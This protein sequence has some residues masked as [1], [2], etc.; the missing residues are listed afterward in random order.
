[1]N[2]LLLE[3]HELAGEIAVVTDRRAAHVR[4]ILGKRA[5]ESVRVGL[6]GGKLGQGTLVRVDDGEVEI[7]CVF[8]TE[9]PPR[10]PVT[11]VLALPRPPVLRRVLQH[12]ASAGVGR[13]VLVNAARVE[14]SYWK[15]PALEPATMRTQLVLGLEQG[16][17][18]IVP[19]VLLRPRFRPFVEDELPAL[20]AG[21]LALVA[22]PGAPPCPVDVAR[23]VTLVVGPEGG[24]VPFELDA[25]A[26]IGFSRVGL[27]RRILRVETA[28]VALLARVGL[29]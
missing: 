25:L 13:I 11:L 2:V 20:A 23:A 9:P 8:D 1:V 22:D 5:G 28:V 27:G 17:D 4:E 19:D 12:V 24:L 18:T 16:G 21:S 26:K 10:S 6:L 7:C 29:P 14:K 15:S 3:P